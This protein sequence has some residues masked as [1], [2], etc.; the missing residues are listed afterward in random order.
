[1]VVVPTPRG[2][3]C[4]L[5]PPAAVHTRAHRSG[6]AE[7][8]ARHGEFAAAAGDHIVAGGGTTRTGDGD[9]RCALRDGQALFTDGPFAEGAGGIATGGLPAVGRRPAT[10]L[11]SWP[12]G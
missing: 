3:R 6:E 1:V 12:V 8:G 10:R 7:G 2:W 9:D 11:S 4:L 5:E